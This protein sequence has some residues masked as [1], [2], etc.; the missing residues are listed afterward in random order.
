MD[1]QDS[2]DED[3]EDDAVVKKVETHFNETPAS[4][5]INGKTNTMAK[6]GKKDH[7]GDNF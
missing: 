4:R 2:D 5:F 7:K 6:S 1:I 3:V